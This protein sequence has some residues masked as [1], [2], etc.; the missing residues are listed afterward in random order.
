MQP[1]ISIII[2]SYNQPAGFVTAC[3]ESIRAQAGA[4][5]EIIFVDGG[6]REE[7]LAAAEPYRAHCSHF[8]SER[9]EGQ[10]DAIN[11]GL[12]LAS[13]SL[14]TW[15]NTDDIYLPGAFA[16]MAGAFHKNPDAPF[17]MG[18]GYRTDAADAQRTVFYPEN[19]EFRRD[20]FEL[21][22]NFILQPSTFIRREALEKAGGALNKGLHY[23][24]DTELW[25][26][27][28]EHGE[29]CLVPFPVACIREYES[30]KTATGGWA[31][32]HEIQNLAKQYT[33]RALTPGVLAELSRLLHESLADPGTKVLFPPESDSKVLA[34]WGCAAGGLRSLCGRDDG[35]P[36]KH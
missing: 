9:D 12:R 14:V 18:L 27:L 1:E 13:G 31:R 5:Y 30:T 23:A 20:A 34:L 36:V 26:R 16:H 19:F 17:Y 21:G 15:L 11:K 3:F 2:P 33:G 10:A 6:S 8:I 22:L 4:E 25:F 7:T 32:F 24:L 35:F 28:L 29:P